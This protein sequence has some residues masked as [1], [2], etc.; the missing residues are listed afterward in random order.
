M[1]SGWG[2]GWGCYC[3]HV[4]RGG[5]PDECFASRPA[6]VVESRSQAER[7]GDKNTYPIGVK[8]LMLEMT[9]S[10]VEILLNLL[11]RIIQHGNVIRPN[12]SMKA[13][14]EIPA[15]LAACPADKKPCSYSLP[16]SNN[17]TFCRLTVSASGNSMC[18][19]CM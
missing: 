12:S 13:C 17:W 8:Q 16:V 19:V 2:W 14:L 9:L 1:V 18:R 15:I 7:A 10:M 3:S 5:T 11:G 4:L 6:G